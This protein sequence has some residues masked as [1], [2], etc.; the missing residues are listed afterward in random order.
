MGVPMMGS[1]RIFTTNEDLIKVMPFNTPYHF[2]QIKGI[3]FGSSHPCAVADIAI[4]LD[5]DIIYVTRTWKRK[6]E[7]IAEHCEAINKVNPWV[8]VAWPHDGINHQKGGKQLRQYYL[9]FGVKLLSKTAS[10]DNKTLGAQ[11]VMPIILYV[12]QMAADGRFKVFNTCH[13]FFDEWRNYH[14]DDQGRPVKLKDDVLKAVFYA[15][16]MR[17]YATQQRYT[18][19]E[20]RQSTPFSMRL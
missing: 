11:E 3:D 13:E 14:Y 10:Y 7:D 17:R 18:Q 9:D 8:P 6:T 19:Y 12:N 1:G 5:K 15:V 4:D 2:A 16:M 20:R